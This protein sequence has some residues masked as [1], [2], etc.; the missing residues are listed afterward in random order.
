MDT[1]RDAGSIPAASTFH[2]LCH[3]QPASD[4]QRQN[5]GP[6]RGFRFSC[7]PLRWNCQCQ[8]MSRNYQSLLP[9]TL[10]IH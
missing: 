5:P 3:P 8:R 2:H 9:D 1:S 10:P 7:P 6:S 4:N